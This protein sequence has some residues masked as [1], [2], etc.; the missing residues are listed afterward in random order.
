MAKCQ[1]CKREVDKLDLFPGGICL[2][3]YAASEEGRRPLTA[4]GVA[5]MF[6]KVVK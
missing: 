3:C 2:E 1:S 6:R 4:E 5:D